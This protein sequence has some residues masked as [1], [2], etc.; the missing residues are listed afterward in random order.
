[1]LDKAYAA[2]GVAVTRAKAFAATSAAQAPLGAANSY[3]GRLGVDST[4]TILVGKQG[5]ALK[6]VNVDPADTA[7]YEKAIDALLGGAGA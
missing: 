4:P 7:G 5:G 6:K 1:L 2:A 3:A